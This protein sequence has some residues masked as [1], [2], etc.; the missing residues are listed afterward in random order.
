MS[1]EDIIYLLNRG[2]SAIVNAKQDL[3][4]ILH[5]IEEVRLNGLYYN[6]IIN[7][8]LHQLCLRNKI[9]KDRNQISRSLLCAREQ[10]IIDLRYS[11]KTSKEIA[12]ILFL[13]KKTIDK[14]FGDLYRRFECNNFFE[15]L[16][17]CK[18]RPGKESI[19]TL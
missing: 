8:A 14:I 15:L 5:A 3:A 18:Y 4:E 9:L 19:L 1:D 12:E 13:S 10:Q 6:E 17:A 16:N 2:A 7:K 11:G